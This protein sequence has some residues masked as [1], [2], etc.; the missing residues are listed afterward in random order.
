MWG[1]HGYEPLSRVRGNW[2][3]P[4]VAVALS[5]QAGSAL[6]RATGEGHTELGFPRAARQPRSALAGKKGVA[7]S[8]GSPRSTGFSPGSH[9][10]QPSFYLS[11]F[12][13]RKSGPR[14]GAGIGP[15]Y[16]LDKT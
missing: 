16:A 5:C 1:H 3:T 14:L 6:L 9:P 8:V 2:H 13:Q 11:F 7:L 10:Y 15:A 12:F 4:R